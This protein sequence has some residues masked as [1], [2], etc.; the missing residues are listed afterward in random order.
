MRMGQADVGLNGML[1]ASTTTPLQP[2]QT[3]PQ[4]GTAARL[5]P[6]PPPTPPPHP[7]THTHPPPYSSVHHSPLPQIWCEIW[8]VLLLVGTNIGGIIQMG[9]S[10]GY[11]VETQWPDAPSWLY[12]RSGTAAMLFFTL[13]VMF[14]LCMLPQMRKVGA[15]VAGRVGGG[16]FPLLQHRVFG[17]AFARWYAWACPPR[18]W[19]CCA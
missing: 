5:P 1:A 19:P 16:W 18:C 2:I 13:G 3:C 9:E 15:S 12:G 14:P 17:V 8:I 7:P 6:F 11:A 10:F 4:Q